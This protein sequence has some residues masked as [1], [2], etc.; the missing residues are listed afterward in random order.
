M[1]IKSKDLPQADKIESVI[2][3][4][5]AIANGGQTDI[6]IANQIPGIR[7][8]A[9]QGRYYRDAAV[10]LGFAD[11]IRNNAT[12]TS[13]G[14]LIAANP[15]LSNS[16]LLESVLN[17][18][19]YQKL[20]PYVELHPDGIT[21]QQIINYLNLISEA[22]I[23]KTIIPR[24]I[25]SI[26][27]WIKSLGLIAQDG[28]KFKLLH[29][30]IPNI[31]LISLNDITQPILPRTGELEE[32]T[33]IENRISNAQDIITI[34]KKQATLERANH[35]HNQLIN[36]VSERIRRS[37]GIPKSNQ[38]IDLATSLQHD[39]IFEM[40]STTEINVKAQVMK[41]ISQLYEYRYIQNRPDAKLI[42]VVEKPLGRNN[43]WMIDYM[44]TDRNI[45]LVWDGDGSLYGTANSRDQ[46]SFLELRT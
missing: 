26:L 30:F 9:R 29:S 17:I 11:N 38:F 46:L 43:S 6:E 18:N 16:T 15:K 44:E 35:S 32:Y 12:I 31:P 28:E 40:K 21:R 37:G 1:K 7:G 33:L 19:L 42:L 27:G 3:A 24:R 8:D 36:L 4:T 14:R 20:M 10:M 13:K 41:G 45:H 22:N 23:G 34:Y 5:I 2:A 39:Y 25:F